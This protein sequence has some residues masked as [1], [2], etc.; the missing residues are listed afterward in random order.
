ML[1]PQEERVEEPAP[2]SE[3]YK[4]MSEL[5]SLNQKINAELER[6]SNEKLERIADLPIDE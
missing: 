4:L 3:T 6:L 1:L 5:I 2:K